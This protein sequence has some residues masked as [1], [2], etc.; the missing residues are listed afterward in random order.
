M[1]T[2]I[3]LDGTI[4]WRDARMICGQH[5][6]PTTRRD[7][8]RKS[9]RRFASKDCE[10]AVI[11]FTVSTYLSQKCLLN[12]PRPT[13]VQ[14]IVE[15]LLRWIT[16]H[17]LIGRIELRQQ[18]PQIRRVLAFVP[19]ARTRKSQIAV[20]R[21]AVLHSTWVPDHTLPCWNRLPTGAMVPGGSRQSATWHPCDTYR[22]RRTLNGLFS[23][24]S[25]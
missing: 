25:E 10:P 3:K 23:T 14:Q 6:W 15:F 22:H 9:A 21:N 16:N 11:P 24:D 19:N 8:R 4:H 2:D 5:G 12:N 18:C 7:A 17:G 20:D 13:A 1:R